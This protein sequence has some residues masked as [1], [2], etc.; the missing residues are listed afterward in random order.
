MNK[1]KFVHLDSMGNPWGIVSAEQLWVNLYALK[2]N[3]PE[4]KINQAVW[5]DL[6]NQAKA[7]AIEFGA[8]SL[9]CRIRLEYE[10]DLFRSVLEKMGF[11]KLS[12]RVEYQSDLEDLPDDKGTPL[13]WKTAKELG[14]DID[15][16]SEFT[17]KIIKDALDIDPNEKPEDFIQDWLH[18]HEFTHGTDCIAIGFENL[19]P[20]AL[21]VAQINRETGWSRIS[22]MGVIPSHRAKGLGKWVH[23]QGFEMMKQQGG[24]LYHG[25][26]HAENMPM[27]ALFEAHGCR[28]HCEMEEWTLN[29]K[30]RS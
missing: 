2:Y 3:R 22:Y 1:K 4:N 16:I 19:L 7:A 27:R 17:K 5:D 30:A 15:Q 24:K 29:V 21:V 6:F 10:P 9:A 26:T 11:S 28:T 20:C 14:W 18:H 12:G 23:R 25:G 13:S 8:E